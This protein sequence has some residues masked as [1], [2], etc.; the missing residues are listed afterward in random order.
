MTISL[1]AMICVLGLR[2]G[3]GVGVES[4]PAIPTVTANL[5]AANNGSPRQPPRDFFGLRLGMK[6]ETARSRLRKIARQ[7]KEEREE[8]EGGEQEVWILKRDP[9]FKYV[10]VKFSREHHLNWIT[11]VANPKRI[12]YADIASLDLATKATDGI[13][14]SYKWKIETRKRQPAFMIIARG[15]DGEFLTSYSVYLSR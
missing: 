5:S 7:E 2:P 12:R 15:A 11:A 9:E 14:Y 6:E 3:P 4:Q 1:L 13:N 8:E 10:L